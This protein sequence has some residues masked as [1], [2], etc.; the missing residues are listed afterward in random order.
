SG[1]PDLRDRFI[2]GAGSS[3][4]LGD[5][6]GEA[7]HTL[8]IAEMPSH[9]HQIGQDQKYVCAT[10]G[11]TYVARAGS[12]TT[13]YWNT[14]ATGGGQAHENRPPYYALYFIMKA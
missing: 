8:T 9:T 11:E 12:G 4:A 5:T 2:V 13:V 1:T 10:P 6:G 3:Y 14:G 7:T